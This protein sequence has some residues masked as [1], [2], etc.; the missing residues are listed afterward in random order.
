MYTRVAIPWH[1]IQISTA[2]SL[3]LPPQGPKCMFHD[4]EQPEKKTENTD[5]LTDNHIYNKSQEGSQLKTT[6]PAHVR[7]VIS[8]QL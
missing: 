3:Y 6:A 4:S 5:T 2:R 8:V 1:C 7:G